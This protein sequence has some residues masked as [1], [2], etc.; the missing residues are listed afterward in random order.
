MSLGKQGGHS[1]EKSTVITT[2]VKCSGSRLWLMLRRKGWALTPLPKGW[3]RSKRTTNIPYTLIGFPRWLRWERIHL[4]SRRS[5]FN[6][7]T[8]K[9]PWG[10]EWQPTPVFL[11]GESHGQRS[12]AG[13]SPQDHKESDTT[14]RLTR[15]LFC[16][17]QHLC[18]RDDRN[19]MVPTIDLPSTVAGTKLVGTL[20]QVRRAEF[21][22]C[23]TGK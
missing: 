2:H 23:N 13:Y 16:F 21:I 5:G 11:P 15:S 22:V 18:Q 1:Q 3:Q 14:E 4:Q 9:I 6:P 19:Q 8:W 12:L 20:C 7:W 17:S 10:R